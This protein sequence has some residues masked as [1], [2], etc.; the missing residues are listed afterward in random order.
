MTENIKT[1]EK[2]RKQEK[3]REYSEINWNI[4]SCS[5]ISKHILYDYRLALELNEC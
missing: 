3:K 1:R 2:K 4:F 5:L